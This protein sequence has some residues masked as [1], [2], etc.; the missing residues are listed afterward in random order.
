[1]I[2]FPLSETKGQDGAIKPLGVL[3][4]QMVEPDKSTHLIS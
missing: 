3:E 2:W 4:A 1:M